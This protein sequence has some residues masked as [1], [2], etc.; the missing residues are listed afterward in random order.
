M[1]WQVPSRLTDVTSEP[2]RP[3]GERILLSQATVGDLE[4]QFVLDALRSG[5]VAPL[6]P[7]VDAFEAEIAARCGI[8]HALALSSGTAAL[9]LALEGLGAGPDT[10]VVLSSLT[11]AATANA[12]AYTG[13]TPVFVDARPQ[14]G[15]LDPEV[16]D[17]ALST[18]LAEGA[19]IAAV[20]PVDLLGRVCDYDA[21][22]EVIAGHEPRIPVLADAAEAVGA[23]LRGRPAG[24]FGRAG[25]LSFNGNKIMTTSGGGMLVSDDGDLI[26]RARYLSTQARQPVP[27]YEHTD[28]GYNYRLSNLLAALGRA[29][30]SRLDD[31]IAR[32]RAIREQYAASLADLPDVRFLGRESG[33][34]D[35]EDNCWLT[36][37]VLG[38]DEGSG[39]GMSAD[40]VVAGLNAE[41]IEARHLWKPMHLQ[42]VFAQSRSFLTG[43]SDA[44]FARGVALP[45]GAGLS[46]RD[47]ERV[48]VTLRRVLGR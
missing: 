24:S 20:I 5:W 4:E 8:G 23:S 43:A 34:G 26:E 15:N 18:L 2:E 27:W 31:L 29:Q 39:A 21:I 44:L 19:D 28:I 35:E 41:N 45:S 7:H 22:D 3:T 6:G 46:E 33:R 17:R 32:R 12:V 37:I 13:A 30:L 48:V 40:D 42:P 9:H 47:I 36:A 38:D 11:F 14:D 1:R 10:V 25:A 16:L